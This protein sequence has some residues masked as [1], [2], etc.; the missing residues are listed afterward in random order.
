MKRNQGATGLK[1]HHHRLSAQTH[2]L[3]TRRNLKPRHLQ[4]YGPEDH[5]TTE[6]RSGRFTAEDP[7]TTFPNQESALDQF[8]GSR[9]SASAPTCPLESD[10][11]WRMWIITWH[12]WFG[13]DRFC[14][15]APNR[16][17]A[18][19]CFSIHN[20]QSTIHNPQS[21]IHNPRSTTHNPRPVPPLN[22]PP[23]HDTP[24]HQFFPGSVLL[25]SNFFPL[26]FVS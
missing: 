19:P 14:S 8:P 25:T 1:V 3:P 23:I 6:P 11:T 22:P 5:G 15:P 18:M 2:R 20:P 17:R 21:T 12:L 9:R 4:D 16:P 26:P 13:L 10:T 24:C 7:P